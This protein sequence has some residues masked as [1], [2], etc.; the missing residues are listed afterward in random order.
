[1]RTSIIK[2]KFITE[3]D[4][5][6][7]ILDYVSDI[8]CIDKRKINRKSNFFELGGDSLKALQLKLNIKDFLGI[9]I[10]FTNIYDDFTLEKIVNLI[11]G[12]KND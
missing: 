9:D 6:K 8:L 5:M 1:M 11:R 10:E 7:Y 12:D 3:E 4:L 2:N